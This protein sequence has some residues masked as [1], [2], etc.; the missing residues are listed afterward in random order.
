MRQTES[1]PSLPATDSL[2]HPNGP[3]LSAVV[4]T[5][6]LQVGTTNS[7]WRGV[8][9]GAAYVLRVNAPDTRSYGA[10]R[11]REAAVLDVIQGNDWA[12]EVFINAYERG[13]LLMRDHGDRQPVLRSQDW[14]PVLTQ[15]QGIRNIPLFSYQEL[16]QQYRRDLP[17]NA[18]SRRLVQALTET[19]ARL[20]DQAFSLVHHDLHPG[21]LVSGVHQTPTNWRIIDWEYS[22]KGCPWLDIA[23]VQ[24]H[25]SLTVDEIMTLPIAQ[26]YKRGQVWEVLQDAAQFNQLL[27]KAWELV[28]AP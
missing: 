28:R 25:W 11:Y 22:G 15:W 26:G 16:I 19:L 18:E 9:M 3:E 1:Y 21:N 4:W 7:L 5:P 20:P 8:T 6:L 24:Q 27:T 14:L 12:P 13:W 23:A 10:S 17:A 2:C